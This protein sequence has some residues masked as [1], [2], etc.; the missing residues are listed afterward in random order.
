MKRISKGS[1]A[2]LLAIT[3]RK[4]RRGR[5]FAA[6]LASLADLGFYDIPNPIL[7]CGLKPKKK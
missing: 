2:H 7:P 6:V 4:R 5:C 1:R 3:R